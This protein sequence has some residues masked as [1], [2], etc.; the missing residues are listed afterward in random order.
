VKK[1]AESEDYYSA[2]RIARQDLQIFSEYLGYRNARFHNEW[3]D[4]LQPSNDPAHFSPLREHPLALKKYHLEAPRKHAKSE[5]IAINYVSWLIGN[6]PDIHITIV[7]KSAEL[8]EQTVNAIKTRMEN[9][10]KYIDVFSDL[11]PQEAINQKWTGRQ[12]IV[13]RSRISKFPTLYATGL[14]GSLT[15]GGNDL[16][17]FDDVIDEE[18]CITPLSMERASTWVFKVALTTLFPWGAAFVLGTRWHHADLYTQLLAKWPHRVYKAIIDEEKKL[19]LWPE[20][21]SY[22]LLAQRRVDL[23]SIFF[24][25]QYQNDPTGMEGDLLKAEWLH[26]WPQPP[27]PGIPNYCGIDPSLGEGDRFGIATLAYD[28]G[29]NKGWLKDVWAERM[30]FPTI[31]KEKIPQLNEL[32]HYAKIYIESNAFQKVL[33]Y[34]QELKG[35]P[36]VP[37]QT[38]QSK[39]LRFTGMASMSSHFEAS[40][41][42][43]NPLLNNPQSE[44]YNEWVQFPRGQNDDALDCVEI[45]VRN[46]VGYRPKPWAIAVDL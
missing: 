6:Y 23:G 33:T 25:C 36:I 30:S 31:L 27:S 29:L 35:L 24:R 7:S 16:L 38:A 44:F 43:V 42:E 28:K 14:H 18:D 40:R 11:K 32:Y 4:L 10:Q 19:V 37:T 26:S 9:D 41:V 17:V 20:V 3:Y 46:T 39:E 34:V 45:V 1:S 21:W 15:G 5:C 2:N 13:K 12:L 22:E 8:A